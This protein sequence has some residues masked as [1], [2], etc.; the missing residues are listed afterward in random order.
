MVRE[1]D[2]IGA[3]IP[4]SSSAKADDPVFQ[5]FV[6]SGEDAAYWILRRSLS[7]GSPKARPGGGV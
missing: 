1:A 3:F 2:L 7:S 6:I 4:T 5:S